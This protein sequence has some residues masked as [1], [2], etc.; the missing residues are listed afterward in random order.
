[1][2]QANER[3]IQETTLTVERSR[4]C[5]FVIANVAVALA[6]QVEH[7]KS[8]I[9]ERHEHASAAINLARCN[10][11]IKAFGV[12]NLELPLAL[13]GEPAGQNLPLVPEPARVRVMGCVNYRRYLAFISTL[14][15]RVS[16]R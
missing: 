10:R 8:F 2:T 16:G 1:M 13:P 12:P 11:L 7:V 5:E 14:S 15:R 4:I 6:T 9:P 3:K